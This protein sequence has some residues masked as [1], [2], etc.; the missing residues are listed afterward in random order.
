M[1]GMDARC[2]QDLSQFRRTNSDCSMHLCENARRCTVGEVGEGG[3]R[4]CANESDDLLVIA[5][6]VVIV[7]STMVSTA[8]DN[9]DRAEHSL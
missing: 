3:Y 1:K 2:S 9:G 4:E 5:I 8:T 7:Q 6:G